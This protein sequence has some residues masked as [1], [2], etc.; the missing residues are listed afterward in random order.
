VYFFVNILSS[1]F[2]ERGDGRSAVTADKLPGEGGGAFA[3]NH[4]PVSPEEG[5]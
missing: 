5:H 3:L 2:F 1:R 4:A